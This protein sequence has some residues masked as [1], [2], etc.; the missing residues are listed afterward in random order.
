[1]VYFDF[2]IVQG[3]TNISSDLFMLLIPLPLVLSAMVPIKQKVILL[4]IFSMG[5]FVIVAA[6]I[7]KV[8]YFI[9][10]YDDSFMFWYTREASVAVYVANLPCIWPLL[11]EGLPVLRSWTPGWMSSAMRYRTGRGTNTHTTRG[12]VATRTNVTRRSLEEFRKIGDSSGVGKSGVTSTVRDI[13]DYERRVGVKH[14][15]DKDSDIASD[16]LPF[17]GIRA[18]TTIELSVLSQTGSQI[19]SPRAGS[20]SSVKSNAYSDVEQGYKNPDSRL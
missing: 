10:I 2:L 18:E 13:D 8:E 7:T 5:I 20:N 19:S 12:G 11:R 14:N 4:I 1:M 3:I 6:T 17:Q 9:S 15:S 16:E